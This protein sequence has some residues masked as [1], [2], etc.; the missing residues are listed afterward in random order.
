MS[1]RHLANGDKLTFM[2]ICVKT[3][4]SLLHQRDVET[5]FSTFKSAVERYVK[6]CKI[7]QLKV[8]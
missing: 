5:H 1:I 2:E 6:I 3:P 7:F 8:S 4:Q